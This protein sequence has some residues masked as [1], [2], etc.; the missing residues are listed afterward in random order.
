MKKP[1]TFSALDQTVERMFDTHGPHPCWYS[2][3]ELEGEPELEPV[4]KRYDRQY[5]ELFG[6]HFEPVAY[7]V[8]RY[9]IELYIAERLEE[10]LEELETETRNYLSSFNEYSTGTPNIPQWIKDKNAEL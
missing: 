2:L 9:Y 6:D 5:E 1:E 10:R 7:Q 4:L 3:K 8:E